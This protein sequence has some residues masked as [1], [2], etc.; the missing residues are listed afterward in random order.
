VKN[1][2]ATETRPETLRAYV[3]EK[4][5][6]PIPVPAIA[7]GQSV[8]VPV[9]A[10]FT[11]AGQGRL[12]AELPGDNLSVDD[13]RHVIVPVEQHLRI[14]VVNGEPSS[15]P[16]RDEAHLFAVALHPEGPQ[17]SGN[18]LTV[19]DEAELTDTN[20]ADFHVVVLANVSNVD[21]N[22]ADHLK[23]YVSSGGGLM[24]CLGDQ[25]DPEQYN[26]VL[27][28]DQR[29]L[30][31]ARLIKMITLPEDQQAVTL[32]ASAVDHP[33]TRNFNEAAVS[34]F[35]QVR[36]HAYVAV[37]LTDKA[38]KETTQTAKPGTDDKKRPSTRPGSSSAQVLLRYAD[39]QRSPAAVEKSL[40]RGSVLLLTTSL[41]KEWNNFAD[42]PIYVV[43]NMEM[44]QH[45]AR[46][47]DRT[48]SQ[49]VGQP[50]M[51][52]LSP[53]LAHVTAHLEPP[54]FPEIPAVQIEPRPD[55]ETGRPLINWPDTGRPGVYRFRMNGSNNQADTK[56]FAV[57]VDPS[58]SDLRRIQSD[59]LLKSFQPYDTDYIPGDQLAETTT[60]NDGR[61]ELWPIILIVLI[62]VLMS[63][64]L[65]AWWFS[66]GGN[67]L[68][69]WRRKAA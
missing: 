23:D 9:E 14:L 40:G 5:L 61:R 8:D 51:I 41:D 46:A 19:I 30:L 3:N 36:V 56:L 15:D 63:E 22:T 67:R 52:T 6:P 16:Y 7:P 42:L 64:Q 31:P 28:S 43:W 58:E 57:N 48:A 21:E 66:A 26:Q 55:P 20:L 65:L 53:E 10:I 29:S 50:L 34:L 68:K 39:E 38:D 27:L 62:A 49:L 25:V 60:T 11:Q 12:S 4:A 35:H 59:E 18:E 47:A 37:Q 33:V 24:I 13:R 17:S 45:L 1:F 32:T 44:V 69:L 54:G 2:G